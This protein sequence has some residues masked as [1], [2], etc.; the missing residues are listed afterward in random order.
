[1]IL[2]GCHVPIG[3]GM[4]LRN[5]HGSFAHAG[6]HA[7]WACSGRMLLYKYSTYITASLVIVPIADNPLPL[8]IEISGLNSD[9]VEGE[10]WG[11]RSED[12]HG[13]SYCTVVK[14]AIIQY[15]RSNLTL[16]RIIC[17]V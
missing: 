6:G 13:S 3:L 2:I 5:L 12:G 17:T 4:C 11:V 1:M 16:L 14:I 15:F 8:H 7:N 9:K 10:S